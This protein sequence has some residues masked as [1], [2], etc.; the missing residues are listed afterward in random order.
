[1]VTINAR[2]QPY[3]P[4]KESNA[5]YEEKRAEK[6]AAQFKFKEKRAEE[7]FAQFEFEE[8]RA[9]EELA[10]SK[11]I[12]KAEGDRCLEVNLLKRVCEELG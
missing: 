12:A 8:K 1:M 7:R 9:Q 11:F 2:T 3:H 10:R 4:I 6:R 5:K